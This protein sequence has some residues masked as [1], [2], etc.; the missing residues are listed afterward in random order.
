MWVGAYISDRSQIDR[1][2][3]DSDQKQLNGFFS[4]VV[5]IKE[6]SST[7]VTMSPTRRQ[8]TK[9]L[10]SGLNVT[11]SKKK[12]SKEKTLNTDSSKKITL[13]VTWPALKLQLHLFNSFSLHLSQI[14][15]NTKYLGSTQL[16]ICSHS[17]ATTHIQPVSL[18]VRHA[19]YPLAGI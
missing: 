6:R 10:K 9:H 13:P 12:E 4:K 1:H 17:S 19:S 8:L 11:F 16:I 15:E 7:R 5:A 18:L 14:P 2:S 3:L